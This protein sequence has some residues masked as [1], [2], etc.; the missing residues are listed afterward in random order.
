MPRYPGGKPLSMDNFRHR[1]L[2]PILEELGIL[3]K[4]KGNYILDSRKGIK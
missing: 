4:I 3:A 1:V 2:N